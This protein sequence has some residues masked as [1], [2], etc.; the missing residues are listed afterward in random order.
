M[1]DN[2]GAASDPGRPPSVPP[3]ASS[4]CASTPRN[5]YETAFYEG[6]GEV[7]TPESVEE[8]SD[9]VREAHAHS[10][11][12]IPEGAGSHAY[13]GVP[14]RDDA[15]LISTR[16]LDTVLRYEPDDFTIGVQ[17]GLPLARLG[18]VLKKNRQEVPVDFS[19]RT[20]GTVGGWVAAGFRSGW[21]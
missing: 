6:N 10:K 13:L 2:A 8:L 16:R 14:P 5:Q 20:S 12:V 9:L 21:P 1:N 19:S 18:E 15:L 4:T 3:R 17:A 7:L 11:P